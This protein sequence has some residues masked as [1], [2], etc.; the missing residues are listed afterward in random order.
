MKMTAQKVTA[1]KD[2]S[3]GPFG[4]KC[5]QPL[6]RAWER[7]STILTKTDLHNN[8]TAPHHSLTRCDTAFWDISR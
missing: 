1:E 6:R 2:H 4:I 5:Q 8:D 7:H 3:L